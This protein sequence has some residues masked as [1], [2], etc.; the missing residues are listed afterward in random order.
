VRESALDIYNRHRNTFFKSI[1]DNIGKADA[2]AEYYFS[3]LNL[4]RHGIDIPNESI[5]STLQKMLK[6][7]LKQVEDETE[8]IAFG[9]ADMPKLDEWS[10]GASKGGGAFSIVQPAHQSG[11][12]STFYNRTILPESE[13]TA[14]RTGMSPR[15]AQ[16]QHGD[17]NH[18]SDNPLSTDLHPL[19]ATKH[20]PEFGLMPAWCERLVD[21]YYHQNY[22]EN[23]NKIGQSK[24]EDDHDKEMAWE[25]Q[26]AV[27]KD[28]NQPHMIINNNMLG[29]TFNTNAQRF[30]K[31]Y[32]NWK[33]DNLQTV[34]TDEEPTE[35]ELRTRHMQELIDGWLSQEVDE[36]GHMTGLGHNCYH[37][38][39]ELESPEDRTKIYNHLY[40]HGTDSNTKEGR[41]VT[42]SLGN[43]RMGRLKRNNYQRFGGLYD[44]WG[45]DPDVTGENIEHQKIPLSTGSLNP[46]LIN[47]LLRRS[48]DSMYDKLLEQFND[49]TN[50]NLKFLPNWHVKDKEFVAKPKDDD[51]LSISTIRA[52]AGI[53][54]ETGVFYREGEHPFYGLDWDPN[55]L[56]NVLHPL[57]AP[58]KVDET[59]KLSPEELG[60]A[61]EQ[62]VDK[63]E[64]MEYFNNTIKSLEDKA[65]SMY[66]GRKARNSIAYHRAGWVDP[67]SHEH[68][69][70]NTTLATH[71]RQP[72]RHLGGMGRHHDALMD[73]LHDMTAHKKEGSYSHSLYGMKTHDLGKDFSSIT[74]E[75][76]L[77]QYGTKRVS[78]MT[79][80][81]PQFVSGAIRPH[82]PLDDPYGRMDDV[83][84]PDITTGGLF[85]PFSNLSLER[86]RYPKRKRIKDSLTGEVKF[87]EVGEKAKL[88][89]T[90]PT[91]ALSQN[92]TRIETGV[93]GA[94]GDIATGGASLDGP[95]VNSTY[96]DYRKHYMARTPAEKRL[97]T[98]SMKALKE[99][100][101]EGETA[102]GT[103]TGTKRSYDHYRNPFTRQSTPFEAGNPLTVPANHSASIAA[104]MGV[105]SDPL[106]PQDHLWTGHNDLETIPEEKLPVPTLNSLY[107][108]MGKRKKEASGKFLSGQREGEGTATEAEDVLDNLVGTL[109]RIG[110]RYGEDSPKYRDMYQKI[111]EAEKQL[112][113]EDEG[114]PASDF[115]DLKTQGH[116]STDMKRISDLQATA[117]LTGKLIHEAIK[118]GKSPIVP[119][120]FNTTVANIQAIASAATTYGNS[121]SNII[122]NE[123]SHGL[124]KRPDTRPIVG[125]AHHGNLANLV[126]GSESKLSM[127]TAGENYENIYNLL[128]LDSE[129][130]FH[131]RLAHDVFDKIERLS[132]GDYDKEFSVMK[133]ADMIGKHPPSSIF[134]NQSSEVIPDAID[135][136]HDFYDA[137][138]SKGVSRGK[139]KYRGDPDDRARLSK[140]S[141]M[142][143]ALRRIMEGQDD[144]LRGVGVHHV[145]APHRHSE[146]HMSNEPMR[147]SGGSDEY[148]AAASTDADRWNTHQKLDS[149][150]IGDSDNRELK[151]DDITSEG[152]V[153]IGDAGTPHGH[154]LSSI[155]NSPALRLD[156]G[157]LRRP[158][159]RPV[160]GKDGHVHFEEGDY[161]S[162]L[163][164]LP[165]EFY[166]QIFKSMGLNDNYINQFISQFG[167]HNR[168]GAIP[169]DEVPASQRL[170]SLHGTSPKDRGWEHMVKGK[171]SLASLTN[172]DL[173]LKFNAEQPPP[174][175]PMHRIFELDDIEQL[176]GFSGDWVASVMPE[177]ERYFIRRNGDTVKAWEGVSG[178]S[179]ELNDDLVKSIKKTT[180]KDFF[181]D[182]VMVG[183]ECHVFDIIE[184][185]DKDVHD[186]PSQDRLRILRG[187][188][189]SH[190]NVLL[191][192]AYNTRFTDDAG[193]SHT[194][195]DLEKE[196]ERILLRDAKSTYMLGEKRHPKWVLLKPGKDI[197]LIVLDK[198]GDGEYTY[199][200]GMGP[201]IDGDEIG[202]RAKEVDGETYM[203]VGTV[204][205]SDKEFNVGDSVKVTMDSV[206]SFTQNESDIYTIHAGNIESE[207]E[208][209]PLASRETLAAFTKSIPEQWP[210]QI[211]RSDR[212]IMVEFQQGEV[213]YKATNSGE[214][215]FVHSPKSKSSLLIRMAESQRPFWSPIAGIM[216][217][218]N[219][220]I[221]ED[222]E[223]AEVHQSKGDGKPLIKP[224]KVKDSNY[225]D[226][227]VRALKAIEKSIGSVGHAFTGAKGLGI[228]MATP[229]QS[230]TGP[231][232]TRDQ[233]TLPD[234]DGRP[235]PNEELEEYQPKTG[236]KPQSI[237]LELDTEEEMAHLHVDKDSAVI[238]TS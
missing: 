209:E 154:A 140:P 38:G 113:R 100:Q 111:I 33:K 112:S 101:Y 43:L 236:D 22:N 234:Y 60:E 79:E 152:P 200:L 73:I 93:A 64:L 25:K 63:P 83:Y 20:H 44:W 224:K 231:T 157:H 117:R 149:I 65:S 147:R 177:G 180:D 194:I 182:V 97:R 163:L 138:S 104:Q 181:I 136:A 227:T 187:G 214:N 155:L 215:W 51:H 189:E 3:L 1:I 179:A 166:R 125:Q 229:V 24:A 30:N 161:E 28:T 88:L 167:P 144:A 137:H 119:G 7:V 191:P 153:P 26:H 99:S 56:K 6:P 183:K 78:G 105:L 57:N 126:H 195:K 185:D 59:N 216:L 84:N 115:M 192:G 45:R 190:E 188:M 184:F 77:S 17:Y 219:L 178:K 220:D 114:V 217:K 235:R 36:N 142:V 102:R 173:L 123:T 108:L 62:Y 135:T 210:H 211:K 9:G 172:S 176:K 96:K 198:K 193:L 37:L 35:K 141:R 91:Q 175:Q 128:G 132:G 207:A 162:K 34:P 81:M 165:K 82:I 12:G 213:I 201:V 238:Q 118:Q 74:D 42:T 170:H 129:D 228:D 134:P 67:D 16:P 145:M 109:A 221:R 205:H 204:F 131:Q 151:R 54:P 158:N 47:S 80:P 76:F 160:M 18:P 103:G 226:T 199:R 8:Q 39:L 46:M 4:S 15:L 222:E 29:K 92:N 86:A 130:P 164:S 41:V 70:D 19:S 218:G 232:R 31:H 116:D 208:G 146:N 23:G 171:H 94:K 49:L 72:Y 133:I 203:D 69:D 89:D 61:L 27:D 150:L 143:E 107:E 13:Q 212:H 121:N 139:S 106:D 14:G 71:W 98:P 197:N 75:Q 223:K 156:H 40:E 85:G 87:S 159:L 52:L 66:A 186:E 233:S 21:F 5:D 237:D 32:E 55:S 174:L 120:D 127:G 124:A 48:D 53:D 90:F 122:H 10:P 11:Q 230:P 196:G 2:A 68:A 168:Q 50:S 110:E 202:D 206:T 148:T 95:T 225:W 58:D 169:M